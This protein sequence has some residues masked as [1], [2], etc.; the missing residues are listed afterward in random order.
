LTS[1]F[2]HRLRD[3][4]LTEC[5]SFW[6]ANRKGR[7]VPLRRDIDPVLMPRIIIPHLFLYERA[8]DGRFRCRLFGSHLAAMFARDAT[9]RYLDELLPSEK[10]E[11]RLALFAAVLDRETPAV[12]TG[13]LVEG[14]RTWVSFRRLLLPVSADGAKADL[15][16]GM[17]VFPVMSGIPLVPTGEE[18]IDVQAFAMESD[19]ATGTYANGGQAGSA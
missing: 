8:T 15:V 6:K 4:L 2:S 12:Y 3:T 10:R 1:E 16:F 18:G 7:A 5:W 9:G 17:A 14:A 11:A 13:R 19:L